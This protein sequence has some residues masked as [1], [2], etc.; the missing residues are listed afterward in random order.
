MKEIKR[1]ESAFKERLGWQAQRVSFL[2]QF[3]VA[4]IKARTV[5]LAELSEVFAGKANTDSKYN[6]K[7]AIDLLR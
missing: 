7:T 3:L 1:L 6:L 2:T 4:V 5:N